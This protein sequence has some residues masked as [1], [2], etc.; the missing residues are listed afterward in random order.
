MEPLLTT[1]LLATDGSQGATEAGRAAIALADMAGANLHVVHI[2]QVPSAHADDD[3][4][5]TERSYAARLH[6]DHGRAALAQAITQLEDA[7]G[8]LA[9]A[10]LRY[11]RPGPAIIAEAETVG[12]DLIITGS[13]GTGQTKRVLLGSVAEEIVR[14]AHC[15]VLVVRGDDGSWP[16]ARIVVGYDSSREAERST[17]LAASIAA[18][19]KA[20]LML[21]QAVPALPPA[22]DPTTTDSQRVT[23]FQEELLRRAKTDLQQRATTLTA[24]FGITPKIWATVEDPDMALLHAAEDAGESALIAM[25]TRGTAPAGQLWLGSTALKVLTC[26]VGPVLI[27]PHRAVES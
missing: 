21:V 1:I 4:A 8:T 5:S 23:Q 20:E 12:A 18:A 9:G 13:R 22:I 24:Q 2:W 27:C 14:N 7:G 6:E 10:E 16:P 15:P 26:A 3:L 11:G 19:A 25:G 17:A